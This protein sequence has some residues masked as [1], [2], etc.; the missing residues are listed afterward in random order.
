MVCLHISYFQAHLPICTY[1]S[2][3]MHSSVHTLSRDILPNSL[4]RTHIPI[5][6]HTLTCTHSQ[7]ITP[8]SRTLEFTYT[9]TP[10][11]VHLLIQVCI[12]PIFKLHVLKNAN[13]A[14]GYTL[15]IFTYHTTQLYF[16][17]Q[18][19]YTLYT[20]PSYIFVCMSLINMYIYILCICSHAIHAH[21]HSTYPYLCALHIFTYYTY[22]YTYTFTYPRV[23]LISSLI[24]IYMHILKVSLVNLEISSP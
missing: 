20:H 1:L 22:L 8:K 24:Y 15:W 19:L 10:T 12:L 2:S 16:L 18:Y 4:I 23:P 11:H 3:L 6:I 17:Y 7:V 5:L 9:Y 13:M 21:L 14:N